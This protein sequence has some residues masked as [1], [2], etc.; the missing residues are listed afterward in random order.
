MQRFARITLVATLAL[1]AIACSAAPE[2]E[3]GSDESELHWRD[4]IA[5]VRIATAKYVLEE[6]AVRDGFVSLVDCVASPLGTMGVHYLN[7][8]RLDGNVTAME[9]ELLL[10]LPTKWGMRLVGVEY[11]VP[12]VDKNGVPW[13][14]DQPPPADIVPPTPVVLGHEFDGPMAGHAPGMPW[15][16]DLH[17]WVWSHNP[18]GMFSEWNPSI[19]CPAASRGAEHQH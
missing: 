4:T 9:P 17:A 1:S 8:A 7:P 2:Y 12:I 16:F 18:S 3:V 10:Y 6:N 5:A 19:S 13:V 11:M 15:H 14:S